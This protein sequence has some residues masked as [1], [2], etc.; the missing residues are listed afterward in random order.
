MKTP[1]NGAFLWTVLLGLFVLGMVITAGSFTESLRFTP[2]LAGYGTLFMIAV[3]LAG[4]FYPGILAWTETTLQ[5]LWGG[6][7]ETEFM[8]EQVSP[9]PDVLRPMAYAVSFLV[10]VFL[11]GFLVVTPVFI[12][13]YLIKEAGARAI[14]AAPLA[15]AV[16][17]VLVIGMTLM[18]VEVWAGI[19][20]EI[21]PDYIGGSIMPPL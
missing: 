17:A 12:S 6:D 16:T 18:H 15:L 14:V 4:H 21:V 20:P 1:L 11:A 19:G 8:V 7:E 10:L 9:W 5:D 13:T 3:L 2:Y